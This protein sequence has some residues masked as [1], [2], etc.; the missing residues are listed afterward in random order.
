MR[1][2]ACMQREYFIETIGLWDGKAPLLEGHKERSRLTAQAFGF[3]A[4]RWPDVESLCPPHLRQGRCKCRLSYREEVLSIE[5]SAYHPQSIHHLFLCEIEPT[6]YPYKSSERG[7]LYPEGLQ[8]GE[9]AL[10]VDREGYLLDTSYTNVVCRKGTT[11]FT[12]A[13]PLLKGVARAR[14]LQEKRIYEKS[15]HRDDLE[16]YDAMGLIN[17]LLPL[18]EIVL[19]ISAIV[20]YLS[21]EL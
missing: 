14:L 7:L 6:A 19:P 20:N 13:R 9:L 10:F 4:F 8:E 5:F 16:Q 12:P 1:R 15:I 2:M 11:W 18:G 17:A 21:T 3:Q